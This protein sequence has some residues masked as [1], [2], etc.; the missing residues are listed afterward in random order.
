M[1]QPSEKLIK[2]ELYE[3]NGEYFLNL[4]YSHKDEQGI[5]KIIYP[6]VCSGIPKWNPRIDQNLFG[7]LVMRFISDE[8][9]NHR[10]LNDDIGNYM[11]I[12][13]N[14]LSSIINKSVSKLKEGYNS[15]QKQSKKENKKMIITII[16]S[17]KDSDKIKQC[18]EFWEAYRCTVN[19]PCDEN[20]KNMPLIKKQSDWIKKIKEADLIIAISKDINTES[21]A[22]DTNISLKFGESTSYEMAIA[23]TFNKPVIFW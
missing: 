22:D 19:C 23:N 12:N 21:C 9:G 16:G 10:I 7:D 17:Y 20:R 14:E 4:Q 15:L 3:E 18:K 13:P 1:D 2:A 8:N 5:F 11:Y 6:K